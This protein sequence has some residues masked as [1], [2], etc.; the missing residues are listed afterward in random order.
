[1]LPATL[2]WDVSTLFFR[3]SG[4]LLNRD[5]G[6]LLLR[7]L[8]QLDNKNN[9]NIIKNKMCLP[10]S[11]CSP[12]SNISPTRQSHRRLSGPPWERSCSSWLGLVYRQLGEP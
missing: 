3:D 11:S 2:D 7:N 8:L 5:N 12:R 9:E 4:A 10:C 1:M 6:T